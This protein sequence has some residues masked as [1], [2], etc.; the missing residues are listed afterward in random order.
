M[1]PDMTGEGRRLESQVADVMRL[2]D[3]VQG[4][5]AEVTDSPAVAEAGR[6]LARRRAGLVATIGQLQQGQQE[7]EVRL[8]QHVTELASQKAALEGSRAQLRGLIRRL[9]RVQEDERRSLARDL[10]DTSGQAMTAIGLGLSV[11]RRECDCSDTLRARVD[12]LQRLVAGV[13][14]D[15][16]RLSINL[17][18]STL[19]QYGLVPATEDLIT[20]L[21]EQTGIEVAFTVDG[22]AA[23]LPE[24]LETALYRITQEACTNIARY[25]AAAHASIA[26]RC[27][28]N[29]VQVSIQD[30]GI[31]FDVA[32]ALSRNR[33]GL[34]GIGERADM[35]GGTFAI[36]SSPGRGTALMVEIPVAPAGE[37]REDAGSAEIP[38]P[39]GGEQ[40]KTVAPIH[41]AVSSEAAELARAKALSDSLIDITAGMSHLDSAQD[42]L[43]FV[44]ARSAAAVGCDYAVIGVHEGSHWFVSHAYGLPAWVIGQRLLPAAVPLATEVEL[45]GKVVVV[46][47]T[48]SD[49]R[50]AVAARESS[51]FS[52]AGIPLVA[53]GRFLGA[54]AFVHNLAPIAFKPSE[55][56]FLK[57]LSSVIS[58]VLENIQLRAR[59]DPPGIP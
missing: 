24:E 44:L 27:E 56:V 43:T 6:E 53:A 2:L 12:D 40:V 55:V 37:K 18:H 7:L 33:L 19:D 21:R 9:V 45:T 13:V 38:L 4:D 41:S 16:H 47:D 22:L 28:G 32:E 59:L 29:M 49:D 11:L 35:L 10:H 42:L 23:R 51:V 31:G 14:E 8:Q 46:N 57:H 26:I 3:R 25:S 39:E 54:V 20:S 30:D 5:L 1:N 58:L 48:R 34:V 36:D 52:G 17:R 50:L 15:L